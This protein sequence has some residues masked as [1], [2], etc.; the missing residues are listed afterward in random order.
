MIE[1]LKKY[2]E[3][4]EEFEKQR[5]AWLRISGFVALIILLI[6]ADWRYVQD[7]KYLWILF[8][9]GCTISIVWWY[10]TMMVIRRMLAHQRIITEIM[11]EMFS[12]VKEVKETIYQDH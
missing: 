7:Q 2:N 6:I 3:E 12:A 5:V 9:A 10:W 8:S 1:N 4:C 11:I